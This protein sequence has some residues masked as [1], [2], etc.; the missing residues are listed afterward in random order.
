MLGEVEIV[1]ALLDAYPEAVAAKGPHG[2]PL[3][4]HAE[5]GGAQAAAVLALLDER[6]F[7]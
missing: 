2:I 3:R 6:A 1:R 4:V 5:K 7:R